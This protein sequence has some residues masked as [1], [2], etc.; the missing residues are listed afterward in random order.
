[1]TSKAGSNASTDCVFCPAGKWGACTEADGSGDDEADAMCCG[2]PAGAFGAA[3]NGACK[4]CARGFFSKDTGSTTCE[5]CPKGKFSLAGSSGCVK[6]SGAY[7]SWLLSPLAVVLLLSL[8]PPTLLGA[9]M[10]WQ[11]RATATSRRQSASAITAALGHDDGVVMSTQGVRMNLPRLFAATSSPPASPLP[12]SSQSSPPS[13]LAPP[14][15]P[16]SSSSPLSS[17][18]PLPPAWGSLAGAS[19]GGIPREW[20]RQTSRGG[21]IDGTVHVVN[22]SGAAHPEQLPIEPPQWPQWLRW[23]WLQVPWR[24]G[25]SL[26]VNG[27]AGNGGGGSDGGSAEND[28]GA[29]WWWGL[30]RR[31]AGDENVNAEATARGRINGHSSGALP[32]ASRRRFSSP[33]HSASHPTAPRSESGASSVASTTLSRRSECAICLERLQARRGVNTEE[34]AAAAAQLM[35]LPCSHVF[36]APCIAGVARA[37]LAQAAIE[38]RRNPR[39][40]D[41]RRNARGKCPLCR[42]EFDASMAVSMADGSATAADARASGVIT[43]DAT[44]GAA[45]GAPRGNSTGGGESGNSASGLGE[46]PGAGV[47]PGGQ[48]FPG[49]QRRARSSTVRRSSHHSSNHGSIHGSFDGSRGSTAPDDVSTSRRRRR[50][51]SSGFVA[52]SAV[53]EHD[54]TFDYRVADEA[55]EDAAAWAQ[56]CSR[57]TTTAA[58]AAASGD[59]V[60]SP[61]PRPRSPAL[62]QLPLPLPGRG[63][64]HALEPHPA[65]LPAP[66]PAPSPAPLPALRLA[67]HPARLYATGPRRPSQEGIGRSQGIGQVRQGGRGGDGGEGA[68][69]YDS[70]GSGVQRRSQRPDYRAAWEGRFTDEVL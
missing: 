42:A 64:G 23:Q 14:L 15:P 48:T 59:R 30:V 19:A 32:Q 2:C 46:I 55:A 61:P 7:D 8:A 66:L 60:G 57:S 58:D 11:G 41:D 56:L 51:H 67:R 37:A 21:G 63:P 1:M 31:E 49:R 69:L 13:S 10:A 47:G 33:A 35:S 28:D 65:P 68:F 22:S 54:G 29:P 44:L 6:V 36:H 4:D 5:Q 43:S 24:R 62:A 38:N 17:S 34:Q 26:R 25:G 39:N 9:A 53:A 40:R 27:H 12:P 16:P 52:G 45:L 20:G 3:A 70:G 18:L 50:R